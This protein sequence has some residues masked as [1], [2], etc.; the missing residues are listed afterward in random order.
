MNAQEA[1][2]LAT[3]VV[4]VEQKTASEAA[5]GQITQAAE[6]GKTSTTLYPKRPDW[7]KTYLEGQGY[8][9]QKSNSGDQRDPVQLEVSW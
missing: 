5:M 2:Q 8:T 3:Q 9:V 7:L 6:R 4:T 1:R